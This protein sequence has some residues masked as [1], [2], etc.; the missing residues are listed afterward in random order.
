MK[1]GSPPQTILAGLSPSERA[2]TT[3][4]WATLN[5]QS[6]TEF[7]Q[8][9][10][11]RSDDTGLYGTVDDGKIEWHEL[12]IE[13]RGMPIDTE[14]DVEHKQFKQQL[15]EYI[16]NHEDVQFFLVD[17]RLH[18]CRSH[19]G[20][21]EVIRSGFLPSSFVCPASDEGCPMR[22]ILSA[23]PGQSVLLA[24]ALSKTKLE[25]RAGYG[26]RTSV[27]LASGHR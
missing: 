1:R 14:N 9:W 26:L 6:R 17:K 11:T 19:S 25:H 5:E 12:P 18:I 8:L 3:E 15:L 2:K 23:C 13:L 21:R 16:S 10:D 7:L 27:T 24:P 4:W 20:A 22:Q